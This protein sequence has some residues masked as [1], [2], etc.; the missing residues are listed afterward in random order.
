M[1]EAY[2]KH[3][4]K[5]FNAFSRECNQFERDL[6]EEL[7]KR[8]AIY[9]KEKDGLLEEIRGLRDQVLK[10][11]DPG[12][13]ARKTE[14]APGVAW[15]DSR[16]SSPH[17]R[18][19]K[20]AEQQPASSTSGIG[21]LVELGS[22]Q[23]SGSH[24]RYEGLVAK[25]D[26]LGQQYDMLAKAHSALI[27]KYRRERRTIRAWAG[28]I[29]KLEE[30][31]G[32]QSGLMST[33]PSDN[34]TAQSVFLA[35]TSTQAFCDGVPNSIPPETPSTL[36]PHR[37][38]PGGGNRCV[39]SPSPI[40]P[41]DVPSPVG[42]ARGTGRV[43]VLALSPG[44]RASTGIEREYPSAD[45]LLSSPRCRVDCSPSHISSIPS[46]SRQRQHTRAKTQR[47]KSA[48]VG[49]YDSAETTDEEIE[50][51]SVTPCLSTTVAH[52][53][54]MTGRY[55][56]SKAVPEGQESPPGRPVIISERSLKRKKV[57][58]H[59][60]V[61]RPIRVKSEHGSSSPIGLAGLREVSESLDLDEVG[62]K[63][64][65][66]RKRKRLWDFSHESQQLATPLPEEP[67][68]GLLSH[69]FQSSPKNTKKTNNNHSNI[70]SRGESEH[71]LDESG[72]GVCNAQRKKG[73][74]HMEDM[75]PLAASEINGTLT[76]LKSE[77]SPNA[78][79]LQPSSTNLR[80]SRRSKSMECRTRSEERLENAV[81]NVHCIAED[82][83]SV[84]GEGILAAA[85]ANTEG[86]DRTSDDR[87]SR[88]KRLDALLE[89]RSPNKSVLSPGKHLS[90]NTDQSTKRKAPHDGQSREGA[91]FSG[92]D[93]LDSKQANTATPGRDRIPSRPEEFK[94]RATERSNSEGSANP[95]RQ[96]PVKTYSKRMR[97]SDPPVLD[98]PRNPERL[99][100]RPLHQL[101]LEDFKINPKYKGSDF[102]FAETVRN[103]DQRRCLPGCVRLECCGATLRKALELGGIPTPAPS[104]T[105]IIWNSSQEQGDEEQQLLEDYVGDDHSILHE[106][107]PER[108]RE[109]I[110]Q[111]RTKQFADRFGRHRQP[112]E[113]RPTPPGFWRTDM[114]TSQE[115]ERDREAAGEMV[116]GLVEGRYREAK[117][118]KGKWAFRDE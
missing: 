9:A 96:R 103:K 40:M 68:E 63:V 58:Q 4:S 36:P 18:P 47:S 19:E 110:A 35:G 10:A 28:Y 29:K 106:L 116:R 92:G 59:G 99:R 32:S 72:G 114:P 81:A 105:K 84:S 52:A 23:A 48:Q 27:V 33:E 20:E 43:G 78:S 71:H 16:H 8:D 3:R 69:T 104:K 98:T 64:D 42:T 107:T 34:E 91:M 6:R 100:D 26:A 7:A 108:R 51:P 15:Q 53:G 49:G 70:R 11:G 65:T 95:D 12:R 75:V 85:K 77:G 31:D 39:T 79:I 101:T 73:A 113:R 115:Q 97:R 89:V 66:P 88:H 93:G 44:S 24:G 1:E 83:E 86:V 13:G 14:P 37:K 118:G 94:A 50:H 21:V 60:S 56:G 57:S 25:F 67:D 76:T 17:R 45:T 30:D 102:A 112:F 55:R 74:F 46:S 90:R 111:A 41:M 62:E 54:A 22:D 5:L 61:A 87:K 109:L 82:G 117:R 38:A 80:L 2:Q